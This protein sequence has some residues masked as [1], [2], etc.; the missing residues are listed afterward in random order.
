MEPPAS[1]P[2][3]GSTELAQLGKE[4]TLGEA[5]QLGCRRFETPKGR[6]ATKKQ[7]A[8]TAANCATATTGGA[9][10]AA[11]GATA[12][13]GGAT[14]KESGTT[15]IAAAVARG[16]NAAAPSASKRET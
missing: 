10:T 11:K 2:R 13:T 4:Q 16:G 3:T 15:T 9:A 14:T 6:P 1:A 8:T 7:G 12:T 5:K